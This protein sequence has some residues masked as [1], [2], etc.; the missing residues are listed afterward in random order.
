MITMSEVWIT[1][2]AEFS[3]REFVHQ[4]WD[5]E[6]C[7]AALM[8][9]RWPDGF[10][11]PACGAPE[12]GVIQDARRKRYQCRQ[13][14]H[15]TSLTVGTLAE[16]TKLPLR[17]WFLATYL[18]HVLRGEIRT[19]ALCLMLK[20][21]HPTAI[22]IRGKIVASKNNVILEEVGRIA[23]EAEPSAWSDDR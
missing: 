10:K 20:V 3:L 18:L 2:P 11:C 9:V 23:C 21:S 5:E 17:T 16:G 7:E 6:Q 8:A 13:C 22:A 12:Y 4:F 19:K 14:R 15:Q 1:F